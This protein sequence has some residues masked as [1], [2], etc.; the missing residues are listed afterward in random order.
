MFIKK[1][2]NRGS[3]SSKNPEEAFHLLVNNGTEM[4]VMQWADTAAHEYKRPEAVTPRVLMKI[5][6]DLGKKH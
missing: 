6:W 1:Q 3:V 4:A 5:W 2:T